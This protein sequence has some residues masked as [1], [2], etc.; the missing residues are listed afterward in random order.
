MFL[1]LS[2]ASP[3]C[4]WHFFSSL[5]K[6][7]LP[8]LILFLLV[9]WVILIKMR[10]CWARRKK[11]EIYSYFCFPLPLPALV[12]CRS[13]SIPPQKSCLLPHFPFSLPLI[14]IAFSIFLLYPNH[15]CKALC[16][17]RE[18]HMSQLACYSVGLWPVALT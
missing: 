7:F 5:F 6:K 3:S 13:Y 14:L 2:V 15:S 9:Y 8:A 1:L 17:E 11:I 4:P 10:T 12:L 16:W 18:D